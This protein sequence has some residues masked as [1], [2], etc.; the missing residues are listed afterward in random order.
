MHT[1][2][3]DV[4]IGI[5]GSLLA[6]GLWEIGR[7]TWITLRR[8]RG[9]FSGTSKARIAPTKLAISDQ[10]SFLARVWKEHIRSLASLA[11]VITFVVTSVISFK[12]YLVGDL[13]VFPGQPSPQ[14]TRG[15][16][17]T[18]PSPE[19][20][21]PEISSPTAKIT[22]APLASAPKPYEAISIRSPTG[23]IVQYKVLITA[24]LDDASRSQILLGLGTTYQDGAQTPPTHV[25]EI[26]ALDV[27]KIPTSSCLGGWEYLVKL[28]YEMRD[29][30]IGGDPSAPQRSLKATQCYEAEEDQGKYDAIVKAANNLQISLNAVPS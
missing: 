28:R 21:T 20:Y 13:P 11:T 17:T 22:P 18:T 8:R 7:R 24:A 5:I 10:N 1:Y 3:S 27:S 23:S 15:A 14:Q 16:D 12:H 9:H 26:L 25:L 19:A 30:E 29:T 6:T 4:L 2:I